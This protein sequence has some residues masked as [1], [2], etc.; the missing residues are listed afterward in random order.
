MI[1]TVKEEG[2]PAAEVHLSLCLGEKKGDIR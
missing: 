2:G 1:K